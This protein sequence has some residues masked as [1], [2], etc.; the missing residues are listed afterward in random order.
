MRPHL[1]IAQILI[2]QLLAGAALAERPVR[3]LLEKRQ[4]N[5]VI[6]RWDN[7]CA[8]AALATILTY[9]L[10]SP[11]TEERVARAMMLQTDPLRVKVRGGFSLLD[12]KRYAAQA[13]FNSDGYSDMTL[14]DLAAQAPMIVPI[15][16]RGYHHFVVVR[17]ADAQEVHIADPG[18]GNYRL[19]TPRFVATWSGIGFHVARRA[20]AN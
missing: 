4:E 14:A 9:D 6:Q 1:L 20:G 5:V 12:M 13:G 15:R 10:G 8:A 17:R 18:F 11:V 2:S 7:S 16:V 19:R 3:S